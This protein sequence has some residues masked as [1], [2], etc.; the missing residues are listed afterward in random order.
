M[1]DVFEDERA[2]YICLEVLVGGELFDRIVERGHYSERVRAPDRPAGSAA[3][4]PAGGRGA[5]VRREGACA[6]RP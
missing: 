5:R 2:L 4:S 1:T 6:A 3:A